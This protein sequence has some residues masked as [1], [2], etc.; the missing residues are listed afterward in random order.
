MTDTEKFKQDVVG[1]TFRVTNLEEDVKELKNIRNLLH[2]IDM[3][4]TRIDTKLK[5]TWY[6]LTIIITGLIGIAFSLWQG[7]GK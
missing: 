1:L 5:T 3:D 4:V 6:F 7:L 2:K